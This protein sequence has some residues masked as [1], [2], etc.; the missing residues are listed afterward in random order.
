MTSKET[1]A[2]QKVDW[3]ELVTQ[4]SDLFRSDHC[5]YYLRG[6]AKDPS[7]GWLAWEDDEK[8]PFGQ[9]PNLEQALAAWVAGQ[10]LPQGYFRLD[11]DFA[12]RSWEEGV[13]LAGERWFE[14]G[15]SDTYDQVIQQTLFGEQVYG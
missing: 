14:E 6:I 10:P 11:A 12:R 3:R 15:D 5:G 1:L 4:S 13:K 7:R 8:H 2:A 9:E